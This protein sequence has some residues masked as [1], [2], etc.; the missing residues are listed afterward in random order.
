[1]HRDADSARGV[2][3]PSCP[4]AIATAFDRCLSEVDP[5]VQSRPCEACGFL[6][7]TRD[8][9]ERALIAPEERPRKPASM[10]SSDSRSRASIYEHDLRVRLDA[11]IA[12]TQP[13]REKQK[14][15][16]NRPMIDS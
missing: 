16:S 4:N 9:L 15:K 3:V 2:P 13:F 8:D 12:R 11:A 7:V 5:V 14:M 1:M 6:W 10:R